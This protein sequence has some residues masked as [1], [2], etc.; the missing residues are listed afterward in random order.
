MESL[1]ASLGEFVDR[2]H[3]M[4]RVSKYTTP[5]KLFLKVP[6]VLFLELGPVEAKLISYCK[7]IA[8]EELSF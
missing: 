1:S 4:M 3:H 2:K 6:L 5:Y 8:Y 7:T